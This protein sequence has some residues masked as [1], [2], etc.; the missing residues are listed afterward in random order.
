MSDER[1]T[2]KKS[3][4]GRLVDALL[5]HTFRAVNQVVPW[6]KLPWPLGLPNL[7]AFRV[8]LRKYNLHDTDGDLTQ[9]KSDFSA[10]FVEDDL[11]HAKS[12]LD[13]L[14][15]PATDPVSSYLWGRFSDYAKALLPKLEAQVAQAPATE[16]ERRPDRNESE[17]QKMA[18]RR[19]RS[20][21]VAELNKIVRGKRSRANY[22]PG[23]SCHRKPPDFPRRT[24]AE[25]IWRG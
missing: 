18:S 16:L 23:S 2:K 12:L 13:K 1:Y 6:H 14:R 25:T 21:V 3:L 20:L 19:I 24:R 4:L 8:E 7:I 15:K 9:P 5:V 10:E 22:S 11:L 17:A